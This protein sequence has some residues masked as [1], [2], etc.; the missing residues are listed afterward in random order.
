MGVACQVQCMLAEIDSH[1]S[2]AA[3]TVAGIPVQQLALG[4]TWLLDSHMSAKANW[5]CVEGGLPLVILVK[6]KMSSEQ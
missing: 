3:A 5:D 6:M 1:V 4:S 2:H